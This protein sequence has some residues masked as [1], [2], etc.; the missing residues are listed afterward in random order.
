MG[1][2]VIGPGAFWVAAA[3][4]DRGFV[5]DSDRT[6]LVLRVRGRIGARV[7]FGLLGPLVMGVAAA[8]MAGLI[9]DGPR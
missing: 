6:R 7:L 1:W 9:E 4:L 5:L 2:L 8:V 3:V